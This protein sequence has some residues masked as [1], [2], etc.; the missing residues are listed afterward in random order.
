MQFLLTLAQSAQFGERNSK[1]S[2]KLPKIHSR[3]HFFKITPPMGI[4]SQNTLLNNSSPVQ[5]ILTCNIPIDSAR[6]AQTHGSIKNSPN[7]ILGEQWG[8]TSMK[9]DPINESSK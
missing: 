7:F 3:G 5:T 2:T 8:K 9:I 4:S 1:L 6:Q